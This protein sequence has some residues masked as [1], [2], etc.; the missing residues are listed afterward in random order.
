MS[1]APVQTVKLT[2]LG[3]SLAE[4]VVVDR[5]VDRLPLVDG[6]TRPRRSPSPFRETFSVDWIPSFGVSFSLGVDGISLTMIALIAVLMP[7]VL[8]A[9]WEEKLPGRPHHRRLLRAAAGAAGAR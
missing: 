6:R 9:S 2:A 8:G 5:A 4:L 3:F 1:G 7:I